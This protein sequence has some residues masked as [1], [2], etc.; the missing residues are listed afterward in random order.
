MLMENLYSEGFNVRLED[1]FIPKE[2]QANIQDIS[3]L[4]HHT[5]SSYN[6]LVELQLENHL[7]LVKMPAT[8]F[9]LKSSSMSDIIDSKS[10]ST[11]N[12]VFQQIGFLG[13]QMSDK[14][15]L[16]SSTLVGEMTYLFHMKYHFSST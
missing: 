15:K 8:S 3:P 11:I 16:Y 6:K 7:K 9:I 4:L 13:V 1:F 5:R 14:G 12:R 2:L 10:D